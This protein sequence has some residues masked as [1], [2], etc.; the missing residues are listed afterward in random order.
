MK[1]MF[2]ALA[3]IAIL[4]GCTVDKEPKK[5]ESTDQVS[6]VAESSAPA[7]T[8]FKVGDTVEADKMRVTLKEVL[9]GKG[10]SFLKPKEGNIYLQAVFELENISKEALHI[11]GMMMFKAYVDDFATDASIGA[12]TTADIDSL[13]GEL[14]AGKKMKGVVGFEV[15]KDYKNV[16]LHFKPGYVGDSVVFKYAK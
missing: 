4:G 3:L 8:G 6:S 13:G 16:E 5:V 12:S 1:K 10:N 2:L 9:E 11:S 7:E 14:A 15:P